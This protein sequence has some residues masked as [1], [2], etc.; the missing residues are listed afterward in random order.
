MGQASSAQL[1]VPSKMLNTP[2][3]VRS[4][5]VISKP[6]TR[7]A[8]NVGLLN[9]IAVVDGARFGKNFFV[10]IYDESERATISNKMKTLFP[11]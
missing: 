5:S 7:I 6:V 1:V 10:L 8:S 2:I 11:P 4:T 3:L 9:S